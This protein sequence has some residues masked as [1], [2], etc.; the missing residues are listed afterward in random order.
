M[1]GEHQGLQGE[2]WGSRQ[3]MG[4]EVQASRHGARLRA[5]RLEG[6]ALV[7]QLRIGRRLR[8]CL[9]LALQV[10]EACQSTGRHHAQPILRP[11]PP[12]PSAV[13]GTRAAASRL[14]QHTGSDMHQC[15]WCA[16]STCS[17]VIVSRSWIR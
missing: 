15:V 8:G 13:P 14:Q 5:Q 4:T 7:G 16:V 17:M 11:P 6:G 3:V 12:R 2:S 9:L 10:Q 1:A